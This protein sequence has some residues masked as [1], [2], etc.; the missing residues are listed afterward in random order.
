MYPYM[1][2]CVKCE[3]H[4]VN[5]MK[6]GNRRPTILGKIHTE[7]EKAPKRKA[8]PNEREHEKSKREMLAV[9]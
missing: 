7:E 3:K 2:M 9:A 6:E 5:K 4:C 8:Q 1:E